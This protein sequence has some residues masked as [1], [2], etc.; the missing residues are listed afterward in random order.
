M[1][2]ADIPALVDDLAP[3]EPPI[4]VEHRQQLI[5][6]L[7]EAAELEHAIMCQYLFAAFTMKRGADEG[8]TPDQAD[9][10]GRWRKV[11][12]EV[13]RQ[14]MLHLALVQNLLTG[15]GAGPH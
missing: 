12:L 7:R 5:Y 10:V 4:V 9:A 8:L 14:E 13:A 3:P 1:P 15:I 11:I 6:L 2:D